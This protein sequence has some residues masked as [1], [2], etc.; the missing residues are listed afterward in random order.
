MTVGITPIK[1]C[2]LQLAI[3]VG[4]ILVKV[5]LSFMERFAN[6]DSVTYLWVLYQK[7]AKE[8]QRVR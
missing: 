3:A 2:N 5:T 6:P 8:D 4:R 1:H 7:K